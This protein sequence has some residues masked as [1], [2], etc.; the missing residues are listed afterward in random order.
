[1]AMC[2]SAHFVHGRF[3]FLAWYASRPASSY[4]AAQIIVNLRHVDRADM[5]FERIF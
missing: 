5:N 1:M 2:V 3:K 4:T